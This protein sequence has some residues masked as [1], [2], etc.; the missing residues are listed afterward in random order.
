MI[1]WRG[2]GFLVVL[3]VVLAFFI[4]VGLVSLLKSQ[5]PI[6]L[7]EQTEPLVGTAL[8]AFLAA[9]LNYI[10]ARYLDDPA[11]QRTLVDPKTNQAYLFKDTSS[12]FF[13]PVRYWTYIL[14]VLG[15]LSLIGLAA[16]VA[17]A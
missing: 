13:I 2:K 17:H 1:I 5:F 7:T 16:Q 4:A 6:A 11:K 9:G 15:V 8:A 10:F 14:L 12:L 3:I